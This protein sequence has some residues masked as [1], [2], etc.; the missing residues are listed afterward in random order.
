MDCVILFGDS[1]PARLI[2]AIVP[3]VLTKGGDYTVKPSSGTKRCRRPAEKSD[4]PLRPRTFDDRD[5]RKAQKRLTPPSP[6]HARHYGH[7]HHA[8]RGKN[9]G[10][11]LESLKFADAVVV[12][13]SFS[14]DATVE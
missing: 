10:R 14:T 2:E 13:D 7:R 3:D 5:A 12:M 1:T 8:Q 9:I 11:C 6:P 4:H